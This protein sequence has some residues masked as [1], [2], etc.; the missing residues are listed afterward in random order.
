MFLAFLNYNFKKDDEIKIVNVRLLDKINEDV[1]KLSASEKKKYFEKQKKSKENLLKEI[2]KQK[3]VIEKEININKSNN[4]IAINEKSK[5]IED[6]E[7]K[8][9]RLDEALNN[10][11]A[12]NESNESS[13]NGLETNNGINWES[14]RPRR[15]VKKTDIIIPD[16]YKS[17]GLKMSLKIKF[18]VLANGLISKADV[19][20]SSGNPMLDESIVSQ[21]KRWKFEEVLTNDNAYGTIEINIAY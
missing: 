8:L 21:F 5:N 6:L 2:E 11:S 4:N 19:V 3:Q 20:I 15:L 14:G 16:E 12:N 13:K 17:T 10:L 18:T 7:N 9:N 1:D